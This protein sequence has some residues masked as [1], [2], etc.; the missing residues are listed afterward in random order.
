MARKQVVY[1]SS[2]AKLFVELTGSRN[3]W[4]VWA[5][6]ITLIAISISNIF[7]HTER[8][9][10][11]EETYKQ[12]IK[13]YSEKERQVF[14]DILAKITKSLDEDPEQD[15][16]GKLYMELELGNDKNGQFFTPY[17]L[18]ALMA[19]INASSKD[20]L[21]EEI[22]KNRY[23]SV[24]DCACGAGAT[25]IAFANHLK[26]SDINYQTS[27]LFVAQDIDYTTALMCYIQLSLL[28]CPGYVKVG[29][30]ITDPVTGNPFAIE[31]SDKIWLTPMMY[32]DVWY[33]RRLS[34]LM[35]GLEESHV[36]SENMHQLPISSPEEDK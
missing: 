6:A 24:N 14:V 28:G 9:K 35:R 4:Q 8:A 12:I 22:Q 7:D 30:T 1:K 16:L 10:G 36:E 27:C 15:L 33:A 13:R 34:W 2:L 21:E 25:L 3:L 20:S 29:N 5:D 23:I 31:K 11:R 17:C 26:K 32:S 19:E 18:C